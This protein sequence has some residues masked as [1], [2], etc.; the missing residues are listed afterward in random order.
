[1]R[2][3][4]PP[5]SLSAR[6]S[7][8]TAAVGAESSGAASR[9]A[10]NGGLRARAASTDESRAAVAA[11]ADTHRTWPSPRTRRVLRKVGTGALI[12]VAVPALLLIVGMAVLISAVGTKFGASTPL[13]EHFAAQPDP[14]E[15]P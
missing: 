10:S 6:A 9:D 5:E 2:A 1:M 8:A 12:A 4:P 3:M 14:R 13:E 15:R 7:I 11:R